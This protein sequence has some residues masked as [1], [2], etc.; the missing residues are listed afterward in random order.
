MLTKIIRS[1]DFS[2]INHHTFVSIIENCT[3][4]NRKY[5]EWDMEVMIYKKIGLCDV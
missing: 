5:P 1:Q 2:F 3:Y 4:T